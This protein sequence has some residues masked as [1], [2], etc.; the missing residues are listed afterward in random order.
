MKLIL[1]REV[2]GLGH[3]GDVVTVK[4][5]YARNYLL[6]RGSAMHGP[7]VERNK[8]MESVAHVKTVRSAIRI[9]QMRS[10]QSS[11]QRLLKSKQRLVPPAVSSVQ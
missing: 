11:K 2:A 9:M 5:G 3:A 1:T 4:D 7:K 6:P 10:R 8:L